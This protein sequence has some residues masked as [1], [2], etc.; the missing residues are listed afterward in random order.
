MAKNQVRVAVTVEDAKK[1]STTGAFKGR[2]KRNV[3]VFTLVSRGGQVMKK[4]DMPEKAMYVFDKLASGVKRVPVN[5]NEKPGTVY[6][7]LMEKFVQTNSE[8]GGMETLTPE[9]LLLKVQELQKEL[10]VANAQ[11]KATQENSEL[12]ELFELS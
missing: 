11:T 3:L 8:A 2:I 4:A 5:P 6:S 7:L 10:E 9:Q 1:K 12:E